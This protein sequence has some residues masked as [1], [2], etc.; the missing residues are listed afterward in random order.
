MKV[1]RLQDLLDQHPEGITWEGSCHTCGCKVEV[2]A[3]P[4]EEGIRIRGGG[5]FEPEENKFFLK[6]DSC[7]EQNPALTDY[8]ECEVYARVVGYLRPISQWNEGKRT[9][10]HDREMFDLG[11]ACA[12]S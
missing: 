12:N 11:K 1:E 2:E 3:I 4:E 5:V 9:E 6:C 10:F 7:M 8:Q